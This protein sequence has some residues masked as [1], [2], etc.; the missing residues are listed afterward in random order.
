MKE[1]QEQDPLVGC[2]RKQWSEKKLDKKHFTMDDGILK[3]KT[4]ING[5]LYTPTV[6]PDVLK[7]CL[8]ILA[9]NKQGHNGF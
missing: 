9:H 2:L 6:V 7:D 5:I 4:V 3:K 8:L 1:L